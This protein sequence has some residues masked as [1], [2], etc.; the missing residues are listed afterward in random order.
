MSNPK[1]DKSTGTDKDKKPKLVRDSFTIP[2][3]EYAALDTLKA[4]ALAAGVAIKKSELL[5]AGLVALGKMADADFKL[6]LAAVPTLK[7]GRPTQQSSN[8]PL[9]ASTKV[10]AAPRPAGKKST[11]QAKAAA[12]APKLSVKTAKAVKAATPVAVKKAAAAPVVAKT[13]KATAKT[14][15][16][17][18]ARKPAA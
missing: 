8:P 6:A 12:P 18:P 11:V 3:D 7:T 4:R 1:K 9:K 14:T 13:A 5:R 10:S 17:T 2:K 15:A 16:K